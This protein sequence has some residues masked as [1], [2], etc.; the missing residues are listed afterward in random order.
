MPPSASTL[1]HLYR[2]PSLAWR[3]TVADNIFSTEITFCFGTVPWQDMLFLLV[4]RAHLF[5][6]INSEGTL[7]FSLSVQ[8]GTPWHS[9]Q[10]FTLEPCCF[11]CMVVSGLLTSTQS[12][13]LVTCYHGQALTVPLRGTIHSSSCSISG[14]CWGDLIPHWYL[15]QGHSCQREMMNMV[16]LMKWNC[17]NS[18][19]FLHLKNVFHSHEI[20]SRYNSSTTAT[21][22]GGSW[23][24]CW[25]FGYWDS[26]IQEKSFKLLDILNFFGCH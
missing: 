26:I 23:K 19:L 24:N 11:L 3:P 20:G 14:G 25:D 4:S 2:C 15:W 1:E 18:I 6:H 8:K 9:L 12:V 16:Y 13:L 17:C 22:T 7:S 10:T 21:R 5:A